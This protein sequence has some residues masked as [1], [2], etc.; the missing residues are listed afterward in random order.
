[1]KRNVFGLAA[2][3]LAVAFSS[4]TAAQKFDTYYVIG[5]NTNNWQVQTQDPLDCN[6][7]D[8]KPCQIQIDPQFVSSSNEVLKTDLTAH[9]EILSRKESF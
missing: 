1:M 8:V 3:V 2:V 9:G 5:E 7:G 4:F 6:S